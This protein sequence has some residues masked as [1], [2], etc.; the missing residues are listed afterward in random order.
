MSQNDENTISRCRK[1]FW[2]KTMLY[3][4][5]YNILEWEYME[6][7][8]KSTKNILCILPFCHYGLRKWLDLYRIVNLSL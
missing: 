5:T 4:S 8:R 1:I 7:N 3:Y 6:Y 2:V